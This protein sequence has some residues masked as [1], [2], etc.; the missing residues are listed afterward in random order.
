MNGLRA[1][2]FDFACDMPPDQIATI[3]A[4]PRLHVV[5]G[6]IMNIR[7]TIFDKHHPTLKDPRVRRAMTHA[8]DRQAIVDALW[9][10][11]TK[12]PKGLQWDFF[13]PMLLG[14]WAPPAY[15]LAEAKKLLK[16]AGY[17]GAPI[18]YQMLN[19]YYTNQVQTA[20]IMAEQW[21]AIGLNV[22]IEM[23][24]N[25]SQIL[26]RFPERGICENSNSSWFNDPVASLSAYVPGGQ[27]WEAGQWGEP[28][29]R[30][31]GRRTAGQH[32]PRAPSR[33]LPPHPD[34][35]RARG[36]LLQRHPPERDL[37]RQAARL[38]VEAGT[39]VS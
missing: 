30:Q 5:G 29:G 24:E 18:P 13:G 11:R 36:P 32:R 8:V 33:R 12:V 10:G 2:D 7:L 28:G 17:D 3:E 14:D 25:W 38:Q 19:N 1:G 9:A 39:V 16:E 31:A 35:P 23:K 26:G 15:D 22:A 27:T 6:P 37:H 20:Q 34:D 4:D 21:K